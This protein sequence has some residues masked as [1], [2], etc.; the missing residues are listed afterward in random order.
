VSV[1]GYTR[2]STSAQRDEGQGLAA[3]RAAILERYPDARLVE[4]VGS[5]QRVNHLLRD[6]LKAMRRGDALIVSKLDR[7]SRDTEDFARIVKQAVRQGWALV[8]LDMGIDTATVMG[9]AM[10]TVG[11]AFA[12]ME[13]RRIGE[14]RREAIRARR[15]EL[16]ERRKRI[17]AL[18]DEGLSQRAIAHAVGCHRN[19]VARELRIA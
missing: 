9:E 1:V 2:V 18:A 15:P 8:I 10:A 7:L 4:E 5:G 6:T 12:R 3:Q 13:R 14:R 17:L 19:A 11:I 16:N